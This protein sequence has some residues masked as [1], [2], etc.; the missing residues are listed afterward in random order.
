M[1][2]GPRVRAVAALVGIFAIGT[3]AAGFLDSLPE[4]VRV[5]CVLAG[6]WLIPA[7]LFSSITRRVL[8]AT[9]VTLAA[10]S[11]F[12]V[13]SLHAIVSEVLRWMGA[14]F[15]TYAIVLTW[16]LV[17]ALLA[18]FLVAWRERH[19]ATPVPARPLRVWLM[20][21]GLVAIAL[22][23]H[24]GFRIGEDAYDHIGYL[25]R[26]ADMN[27]M[28]P[29]HVLAWPIDAGDTLPPDPRKG[30]LHPC[31]AWI[32]H[33]AA[34]DPGT[35][36]SLL[37][38]VLYPAL[39]MTF[40]AFSR[41]LRVT[42]GV[43][44]LGIALFMVSFG[45]TAFQLAH[46]AAAGQNLA[47]AWGWVLCALVLGR[48]WGSVSGCVALALLAFGGALTHAGVALHA[49]ILALTLS[50]FAP[51]LGMSYR[52]AWAVAAILVSAAVCGVWLRLGMSPGETNLLHSH[53]QGVLFV[54]QH[55]FVMSP[56]EV[57]RQFGMVFLGGI[58]LL[59]A[60]A[61]MARGR[62][63]ARVVL[64]LCV[65]PLTIAFVPPV[66]TA[67]FAKGSYMVF[68]ALLNAPVFV[69]SALVLASA[70]R[71]ARARGWWLRVSAVAGIAAWTLVFVRP[72]FD[73]TAAD[74][75][76]LRRFNDDGRLP[77]VDAV[78]RLPA[79]ATVLSD[80]ETSYLLSA[81][82]A[83]RFVALYEQHAN[84]RDRFDL[85]RLQA[86]R[87]VIVPMVDSRSVVAWCER[88]EVDFVVL[89]ARA[90]SRAPGFMTN[91]D[92]SLY[93]PAVAR[94]R[95]LAPAFQE[96][97]ANGEFAVFRFRPG[98]AS[99]ALANANLASVVA[100]SAHVAACTVVAPERAFEITGVSVTPTPA[101]PGDSATI[102]FGYRRDAST[103][104][105]LPFL[106]HVRFDHESL[107]ASKSYPG[108]KYVRRFED[109][110]RGAATRLRADVHPGRGWYEP[111][112][113]PIGTPLCERVG[114]VIPANAAPGRYRIEVGIVQD[115]MLPNFHLRDLLF[116]RDHYSGTACGK[117]DVLPTRE[118]GE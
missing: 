31:I 60:L 102:T 78:A 68:R 64:A 101:A 48:A 113:W 16:M 72:A 74:M 79:G 110:R 77:V 112:V 35:V 61:W 33:T 117:F 69:A 44:G 17:V 20:V 46:S 27:A 104:F 41:A 5:V 32:A 14:S 65:I 39:V 82:S 26:I 73:A 103:P 54:G 13:L 67:L 95:E 21:A 98:A 75:K 62:G 9:G 76:H 30:A 58:V 114:F 11:F 97:V 94:L 57:L 22:W 1:T 23:S 38:L 25:R 80:P 47:A 88:Y 3:P 84:P 70:V 15:A 36:W 12:G 42:R 81:Y 85:E 89:S 91:W 52:N 19:V 51:W 90:L 86:V 116:N 93:A 106:I 118:R 24:T 18:A 56:M 105:G 99:D 8:G 109:R 7:L 92:P 29:D 87:D 71:A 53:V 4:S 115:S 83:H 49:G 2:I 6:A 45:G 50:L 28:R 43:Y 34:A 111:D 63:D 96:V 10:L 100:E 37:S 59:P 66:A 40:A 107:I 108:D 55:A